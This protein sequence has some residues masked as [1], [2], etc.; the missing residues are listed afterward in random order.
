MGRRR[1]RH[2]RRRVLR[3]AGLTA[4]AGI[5]GIGLTQLLGDS[6]AEAQPLGIASHGG[7]SFPR[8]NPVF[9][10]GDLRH[11]ALLNDPCVRRSGAPSKPPVLDQGPGYPTAIGFVG[12]PTPVAFAIDSRVHVVYHAAAIPSG[13]DPEWQQPALHDAVWR[14][15]REG[16]FMQDPMPLLTRDDVGWT[17]GEIRSPS[18]LVEGPE[19]DM[20]CA[21][22]H[23]RPLLGTIIRRGFKGGAFGVAYAARPTADFLG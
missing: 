22:H 12:Y 2:G 8:E 10:A 18:V 16:D 1:A 19:P 21:G 23:R 6:A 5:G 4:A 9:R 15:N 13:A 7:S 11:Q 17:A 20:W 14:R 3:W